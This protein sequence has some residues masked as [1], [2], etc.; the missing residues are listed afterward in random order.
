MY[1]TKKIFLFVEL[2][3]ILN[4]DHSAD[5]FHHSVIK[6]LSLNDLC[7]LFGPTNSPKNN[8]KNPANI[9]I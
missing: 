1:G 5:Y 9:Y 7:L 8:T 6:P 3:V 4:I 2:T